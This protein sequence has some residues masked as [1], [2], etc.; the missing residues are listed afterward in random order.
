MAL[1]TISVTGRLVADPD[2]RWTQNG[3]AVAKIRIA[4]N[5]RRYNKQTE[6]WEDADVWYG[7]ATAFG[8]T[9]E[10]IAEAEIDKGTEVTLHGRIKTTQWEDKE[11]GQKKS[12]EEV[13]VEEVS[14]PVRM[15]RRDSGNGYGNNTGTG[16]PQSDPWEQRDSEPP[17]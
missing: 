6:Q 8:R 5:S 9:A 2:M 7:R 3:T 12:A 13:I 11:S 14:R 17:F 10:A 15:P 1:P 16:Q 4:A